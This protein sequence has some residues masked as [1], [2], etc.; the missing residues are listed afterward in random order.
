MQTSHFFHI[1][2]SNVE[3]LFKVLSVLDFEAQIAS[4]S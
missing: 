1:E 4:F 3:V 2:A